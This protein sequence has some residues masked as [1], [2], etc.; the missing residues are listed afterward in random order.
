MSRSR[1]C[2]VSDELRMPLVDVKSLANNHLQRCIADDDRIERAR[3]YVPV[4]LNQDPDAFGL[5]V[6]SRLTQVYSCGVISRTEEEAGQPAKHLHPPGELPLCRKL[7]KKA[8]WTMR[9]AEAG[10]GSEGTAAWSPFFITALLDEGKKPI[11]P[12]KKINEAAIR[13]A[14]GGCISPRVEKLHVEPLV[15][16]GE[17]WEFVLH[18]CSDYEEQS[19]RDAYLA[20]WRAM[21]KWFR[22]EKSFEQTAFMIVG[23]REDHYAVFPRLAVGRTHLGSY[24]GIITHVTHT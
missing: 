23:Y 12:S 8:A 4:D 13:A 21:M 19:E 20:P 18:D 7:A 11:A 24:A 22:S 14:F 17:W 16:K 3:E 5:G 15:E 6:I 10:M 2:E 1:T 9:T